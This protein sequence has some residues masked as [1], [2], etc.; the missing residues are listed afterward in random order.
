VTLKDSVT[1]ERALAA[2]K[3]DY[4]QNA[5]GANIEQAK[6]TR[7]KSVNLS[8]FLHSSQQTTGHDTSITTTYLS[9]PPQTIITTTTTTSDRPNMATTNPVYVKTTSP[10]YFSTTHAGSPASIPAAQTA[11]LLCDFHNMIVKSCP[12]GSTAVANAATFRDF[13]MKHDIG[14]VVHCLMDMDRSHPSFKSPHG[15]AAVKG[16]QAQMPQLVHED[17][18]LA[19]SGIS[20]TEITATRPAG[21]YSAL[22]SDGVMALFKEKNVKSVVVAG[23]ISSGVV[24]RTVTHAADEGFVVTVL[25]DACADRK[26]EAHKWVVETVMPQAHV[27]TTSEAV[28]EFAKV[29]N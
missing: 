26:E 10:Y 11:L 24:L 29:W 9:G 20:E 28:D 12:I 7:Y 22:F 25:E 23:V 8:P 13:A 19:P 2:C 21:I 4:H 17:A 6:E 5:H 15:F 16:L 18:A 3:R 27:I 1:Q 14:L